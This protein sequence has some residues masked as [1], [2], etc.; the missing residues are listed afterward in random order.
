MPTSA[1]S[2]LSAAETLLSLAPLSSG[3]SPAQSNKT[4]YKIHVPASSLRIY[5]DIAETLHSTHTKSRTAV[6]PSKEHEA[7]EWRVIDM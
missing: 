3:F 4:R 6:S 2:Y 1:L 7:V 5:S